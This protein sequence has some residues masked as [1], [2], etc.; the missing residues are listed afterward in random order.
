MCT[1]RTFDTVELPIKLENGSFEMHGSFFLMATP[2]LQPPFEPSVA[3]A[4][5]PVLH[6]KVFTGMSSFR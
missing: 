5:C 6:V 2:R 1:R 3:S 4:A